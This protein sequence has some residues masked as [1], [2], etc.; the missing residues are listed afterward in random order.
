[1]LLL[2]EQLVTPKCQ[3]IMLH[4]KFICF[5]V[6]PVETK[7][8]PLCLEY[9]QLCCEY[10]YSLSSTTLVLFGEW[11]LVFCMVHSA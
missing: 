2:A 8:V 9:D 4:V 10:P 1:M 6:V 3:K 7:E 5:Q 11:N